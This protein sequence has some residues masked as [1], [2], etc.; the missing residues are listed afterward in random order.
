MVI[1]GVLG[2]LGFVVLV[3]AC[4]VGKGGDLVAI[5]PRGFVFELL[6]M[7]GVSVLANLLFI[8]ALIGVL[9]GWY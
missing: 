9:T 7:F 5:L 6:G 4:F 3:A 1:S 2:L 8:A